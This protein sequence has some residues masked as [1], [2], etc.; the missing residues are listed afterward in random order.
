M[1][2][3]KM[4]AVSLLSIFV[5]AACGETEDKQPES[6]QFPEE[7]PGEEHLDVVLDVNDFHDVAAELQGGL[8]LGMQFYKGEPVQLWAPGPGMNE[9]SVYLY[10]KDGTREKVVERV[11]LEQTASGGYLDEAGNYYGIAGNRITKLNA[12]GQAVWSAAAGEAASYD[13]IEEICCAPDGRTAVL[14]KVTDSGYQVMTLM[15]LGQDGR[16]SKVELKPFKESSFR[17]NV[18]SYTAHLGSWGEDLLLLDGDFIYKIDLQA[19]TLTK[20]VSFAQTSYVTPKSEPKASEEDI[21]AFRI[22]ENGRIELLWAFSAGRGRCENLTFRDITKEKETV[23]LAG[24]HIDAWL[25]EQIAKFNAANEQYYITIKTTTDRQSMYDFRIRTGVEIATGKG[26]ELLFGELM[27]E[28]VSGMIEKGALVD[29]APLMEQAG[30]RQEDYF[31]M[32]FRW[33]TGDAVYGVHYSAY[34]ADYLIKADVLGD[35]GNLDMETLLD[36]LLAYPE[37]ACFGGGGSSAGNV[38]RELLYASDTLYGMLDWENGTCDFSG[39][40][41]PKMLEVAKRYEYAGSKKDITLH[42]FNLGSYEFQIR[43]EYEAEGYVPAFYIFD[44]GIHPAVNRGRDNVLYIN[45][46]SAHPEAAWEF[47]KFILSE[48]TQGTLFDD[49]RTNLPVMKKLFMSEGLAYVE[50]MKPI[51]EHVDNVVTEKNVDA[52][53]EFLEDARELPWKTRPIVDIIVEEARGYFDGIKDIEQVLDTTRNRVQL[54]LDER[55]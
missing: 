4:L 22:P 33:R 9:V 52:L 1:G 5:L 11:V 7:G 23:T 53:A 31:P 44:D 13:S 17:G 40:L 2:K 41:L 47:I 24:L 28:S 34:A 39:D 30:I 54:Y 14:A 8:F 51:A 25:K 46:N 49:S 35:A 15:E 12:S 55:K 18:L 45:A 48:E 42:R 50:K 36:A 29:L 19:G 32:T 26:P 21:R 10:R 16:L 3:F 37:P 20:A 6:G 27:L 43:E 38:L